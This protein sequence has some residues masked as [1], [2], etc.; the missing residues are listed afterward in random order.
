VESI[1][2]GG[3]HTS[4]GSQKRRCVREAE[5]AISGGPTHTSSMLKEG[6]FHEVIVAV[7]FCGGDSK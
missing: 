1:D 6:K 3:R 5:L 4:L 2:E 7:H